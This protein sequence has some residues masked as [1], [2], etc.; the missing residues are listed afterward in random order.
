[1][2]LR[3]VSIDKCVQGVG[4]AEQFGADTVNLV[5]CVL[6]GFFYQVVFG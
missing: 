4:L 2:P 5:G 6:Q 3:Q 1:M